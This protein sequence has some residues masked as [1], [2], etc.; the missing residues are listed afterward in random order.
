MTV[1]TL[2]VKIKQRI[3]KLDSQDYDN[4]EIWQVLEYYNRAQKLF[5]RQNLHGLNTYREGDENSK[6]RIDDFSRLITSIKPVLTKKD[7]YYEFP[8]PVS[9][10]M[11]FKRI[12]ITAKHCD[13]ERSM[14]CYLGQMSNVNN[15]LVNYQKKPDFVWGETFATMSNGN[16]QVYTNGEF[17]ISSL[18]FYYYRYPVDVAMANN[19]SLEYNS[20]VPNDIHPELPDDL[21]EVI[22]SHAASLI[23]GDLKD[24]FGFQV[25]KSVSAEHN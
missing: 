24:D 3:N 5:V 15:Y 20:V 19:F 1:Q 11:Y 6:R 21:V 18:T 2:I 13:K 7:I 8:L 16:V 25:G 22:I 17:D 14:V 12:D 9:N 10:Y 4:L 23:G